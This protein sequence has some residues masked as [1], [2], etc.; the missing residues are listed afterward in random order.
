MFPEMWPNLSCPE[1]RQSS[2]FFMNRPLR[3]GI[4]DENEQYSKTALVPFPPFG[5]WITIQASTLT[6]DQFNAD[7]FSCSLKYLFH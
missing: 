7:I 2:C 1:K 6:N 5:C 3:N 4:A